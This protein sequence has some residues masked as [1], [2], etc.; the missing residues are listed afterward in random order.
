MFLLKACKSSTAWFW[1]LYFHWWAVIPR[2]NPT[3]FSWTL[4]ICSPRYIDIIGHASKLRGHGTLFIN[5]AC[6]YMHFTFHDAFNLPVFSTK[7]VHSTQLFK[8][9]SAKSFSLHVKVRISWS[10]TT[11]REEFE[12]KYQALWPP[13]KAWEW[14]TLEFLWE[15]LFTNEKRVRIWPL[16]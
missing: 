16:I 12:E 6:F 5:S 14:A 2:S 7:V 1:M 11:P 10:H 9:F 3:D 15:Y 13:M 8:C 4:K